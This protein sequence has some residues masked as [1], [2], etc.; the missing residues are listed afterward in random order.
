MARAKRN[1]SKSN[2]AGGRKIA[3]SARKKVSI[4]GNDY[5]Q[6]IALFQRKSIH[7]RYGLLFPIAYTTAKLFNK[8]APVDLSLPHVTDLSMQ[9]NHSI[10][11]GN[12]NDEARDIKLSLS[13]S[14]RSDIVALLAEEQNRL[15]YGI[16]HSTVYAVKRLFNRIGTCSMS[17]REIELFLY[18]I[19]N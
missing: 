3:P 14:N 5:D 11:R 2:G 15:Q 19:S 7:K 4:T 18:S 6:L 12:G 13:M 1:R 10:R 9:F 8:V 16:W 17:S